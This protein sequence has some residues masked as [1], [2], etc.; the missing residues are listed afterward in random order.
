MMHQE[1]EEDECMIALYYIYTPNP[2][3]VKQQ[4]EFQ[5]R[6]C[7]DLS[8][9]GRIRVSLEG[10]NGV[11]SGTK[12]HL[13]FYEQ[14]LYDE[15]TE[16]C[17]I[18][19]QRI[20]L[21]MKYCK[22]R[23][24]LNFQEQMFDSLKVQET[25]EVVSLHDEPPDNES[26][27]CH[28]HRRG[29]QKKKQIK[30][31]KN[32]EL[33]ANGKEANES[34]EESSPQLDG[35]E[36]AQHLS[37]EE[38]HTQLLLERLSHKN[39]AILI[40]VRNVYESKVGYFE[41]EGVPTLLTNTRKYSSLPQVLEASIPH[42]AGKTVYMY[43]TG[44]VRCERASQYLQK[45]AATSSKWE[46]SYEPPKNIYQLTGGIQKYL[47]EFGSNAGERKVTTTTA[48][49]SST[50]S[51]LFRG[52]N[53]VFDPRRTDPVVGCSPAGNCLVCDVAHDD[54]DNGSAPCLGHEA[55]CCRC[56]VLILVC[57]DC[58]QVYRCGEESDDERAKNKPGLFCG[59]KGISCVNNGNSIDAI[60]FVCKKNEEVARIG[61]VVE[62]Q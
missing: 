48:T 53:F 52:K 21:N 12:S 11:L 38:W 14:A 33:V 25:R 49:E 5:T 58:R 13:K 29:R 23:S 10:I 8:L 54:Y 15:L 18:S 60:E 51:C 28:F 16:T 9:G 7:D 41:V 26:P 42:I 62:L 3:P 22:L 35:F 50:Q 4:M 55:R 46:G 34:S 31:S 27:N 45:L 37:P 19:Q 44:G 32:G 2:V 43:C 47:E 17:T 56:R 61:A 39:D 24:D 30:K 36:P 20:N 59:P 1:G 57:N 40:D 6:I